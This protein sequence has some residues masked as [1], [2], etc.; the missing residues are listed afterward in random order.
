MSNESSERRCT[1]QT[2]KGYNLIG[3]LNCKE[4]AKA[5]D[6]IYTAG[7]VYGA[8][9]DFYSA[10]RA[11]ADAQRE[12]EQVRDW[13][14]GDVIAAYPDG[15]IV[16]DDGITTWNDVRAKEFLAKGKREPRAYET[17]AYC[18]I[19]GRPFFMNLEH[20]EMGEVPTFGGP[21]DSYTIPE[22]DDDGGL[23]CER[24]DHDAG[25]WIEGCETLQ[26]YLTTEQPCNHDLPTWVKRHH[27]ADTMS[28][29]HTRSR[30]TVAETNF[31]EKFWEIVNGAI[32]DWGGAHD[33]ITMTRRA[34]YREAYDLIAAEFAEAES[35]PASP[36]VEAAENCCGQCGGP[37]PFDT[38]IPSVVWN[39]FVRECGL[40]DF[41]CLTCIV[42]QFVTVGSGF[43]ATLWS[44][45]FN[46]VPIEVV[47]NGKN[48]QDATLIQEE[49]NSLRSRLREAAESLRRRTS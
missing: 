5:D 9:K 45:Q 33:V 30:P 28:C 3:C 27:E 14:I 15:T 4:E 21:F 11:E 25:H 19:T 39:R 8:T 6:G 10:D 29:R 43:T 36:T 42:Q 46:G 34:A 41:L 37:H 40:S 48:A 7:D 12:P 49:N 17:F 22:V 26:V 38:S 2:H 23:S 13:T 44:E 32:G 18:P 16:L 1:D 35:M 47:V 31:S 24:Y 20:P